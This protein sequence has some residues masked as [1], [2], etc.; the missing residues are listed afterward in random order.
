MIHNIS[1]TDTPFYSGCRKTKATN[2]FHEWQTDALDP[3]AANAHVE[4]DDTDAD[5]LVATVRLGNY[6]QIFKK[7]ARVS[8]TNQAVTAAGRRKEMAYQIAKRAKEI[9]RDIEKALC[10]NNARVAGDASTAR[11]L[12]GLPSWIVTNISE[13]GDATAATGDGTDARVDGTPR[14]WTE[15]MLQTVLQS[16][17]TEGGDPGLIMTGPFNRQTASTF[18]GGATKF[19]KTEDKRLVT[20]VSVYVSD[21]GE[22]KIIPNRFQRESDVFVLEMEYWKV[23]NLRPIRTEPLAKTGDSDIQQIVAELTLEACNEKASG[24]IYDLTS[25]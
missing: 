3:A 19:D 16:A 8:G 5:A 25:S 7:S 24:A 17:F 1:P 20:T 22:L 4:G 23:S 21:F 11:E 9:K 13:A 10:D 2:T 14:A 18:D 12:A 6:T 15:A